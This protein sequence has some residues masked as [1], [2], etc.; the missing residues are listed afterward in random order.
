MTAVTGISAAPGHLDWPDIAKG[1]GIVLVVFGH[2][3]R[4]L[5]AAGILPGGPVFEAVD[6]AIYT[7]HMPLFF[8]LSG[9]FFPKLLMQSGP[10]DLIRRQFWHILYPM[11]VWTYV[12]IAVKLLAGAAVN[13]PAHLS[14]LVRWPVPGYMH[15]WF[16]WALFLLQGAVILLRPVALRGLV[17]FFAVMTVLSVGLVLIRPPAETQWLHAAIRF[18]PWFFLGGLWGLLG[19]IPA[20]RGAAVLAVL[21]FVLAEAVAVMHPGL[22]PLQRLGIGGIATLS[23]LVL[24]RAAGHRIGRGAGMFALL[25]RFSLTIYLMHTIFSA[26]VR[27][28]LEKGIGIDALAPHLIVS[29]LAGIVLPLMMHLPAVPSGLRRGLGLPDRVLPLRQLSTKET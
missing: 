11:T 27:I 3:W 6:R 2:A 9:W 24:V 12:F 4:G 23:F 29:V 19:Q 13:T 17:A 7:F 14:D 1:L 25:G 5:E 28:L 20:T 21:A 10:G 15:L 18:A 26:A 16:L 22:L 8:F